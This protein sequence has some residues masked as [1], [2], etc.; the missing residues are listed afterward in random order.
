M[1][2]HRPVRVVVGKGEGGSHLF[3]ALSAFE[4]EILHDLLFGVR[5][6]HEGEH[7]RQFA[8]VMRVVV[9]RLDHHLPQGQCERLAFRVGE[10]DVPQQRPF[11]LLSDEGAHV[12][13]HIHPIRADGRNGREVLGVEELALPAAPA[14]GPHALGAHHVHEHRVDAV[15]GMSCLRKSCSSLSVSATAR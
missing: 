7:R 12:L 15:P 1:R 6:V 2:E 3:F 11:G 13:F 14:L 10:G 4:R 8:A 5:D 9:R